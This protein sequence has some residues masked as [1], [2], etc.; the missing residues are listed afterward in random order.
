MSLKILVV[1]DQ[2]LEA[3]NLKIILE[4]AGH[5]VGAVAK[6]V[7]QALVRLEK[8]TYDIVI[9]D[10]FLHGTLTGIDLA[11][12]LNEQNIPFIY[13]SANSNESTLEEAKLTG[14]HGFLVKPFRERELLLTLD[15]AIYR[16]KQNLILSQLPE[17]ATMPAS[18]PIIEGIIGNSPKL[19]EALD[20][21]VQVAPFDSTVLILG[22][23]GVGKEGLVH[24]IHALS[25][26]KSKP[27]IKINCAAIPVSLIE[28]EL[29]GHERGAFTGAIDKRIG[30]FELAHN[31]TLF[32]DEIG[33]MPIEVQSKLLRAIQEKEIERIGGR[34]IIHTNV[35]IIAATNRNLL[36]EVAGGRFRMDLY[37]RLNVFPITLSPLRQ[38]KEDIP[39]L[40]NH[41]LKQNAKMTGNI[42]VKLSAEAMRQLMDYDFP[43][44]VRE[45][46]HLIERHFL[47]AKDNLIKS[48]DLNSDVFDD[49]AEDVEEAEFKSIAEIDREHILAAL[50]KCNG[51]VSGK[52]GAA[53]LLKLPPTTLNSRIKKLGINWSYS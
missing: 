43:G 50:K 25:Q 12:I 33:D 35:R 46:Q 34:G 23:T 39:A 52:G 21:L 17:I 49:Y 38:R 2:F 45:L 22:E 14:P 36:K 31:G 9:L 19:L 44:N 15:I 32:L 4:K 41:F 29:F 24:A 5:Q 40:V 27:L 1:E 48:F 30:K 11:K 28:S 7:E 47:L 8:T 13:L 42:S 18:R 16:H 51:K 3:N 20:K 53:E 26:R 10:I 6:S 37:Y